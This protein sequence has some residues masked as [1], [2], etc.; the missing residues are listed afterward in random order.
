MSPK[1]P[2]VERALILSGGGARG[3]YQVGVWRRLQEMDWQPDLVCGT[4]IGSLNGTL[5][6]M[7]WDAR[8][9]EG[10]W[11]SMQRKQIFRISFRRRMNYLMGNLLHRHPGWPAL[12]DNRPMRGL[13]EPII[14][15]RRLRES[16]I[17]V[18]VTATN[19]RRAQLEY[20]SSAERFTV[21]HVM[22]SCALPVVFPWQ[23]ID[24]E[25]YWDGGI[26]ANT[27]VFP[28]LQRGARE[29][30]VVL[31]APLVGK[32]V[33][34]P[35]TTRAAFA[36]SFDMITIASA[37]AIGATL[38]QHLGMD[39]GAT[40]EAINRQHFIDFGGTRVAVV[41]P[42]VP[43][44]LGSIL[45]IGPRGAKTRMATGYTDACEQLAGFF[46]ASSPLP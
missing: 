42:S 36:W 46:G 33:D 7:G 22:A 5:I 13:L 1:K 45:D 37:R 27:P 14:D 17:E 30:V 39:L 8:Q 12:M 10:F 31:L 24:G 38:A 44:D 25:L 41:A 32:P 21:D 19:V 11:E 43:S 6:G 28:A 3:A 2:P 20:F 16:P 34:P 23:E 29:I 18:V 35:T 4:S 26:M 40:A 15:E 9:L